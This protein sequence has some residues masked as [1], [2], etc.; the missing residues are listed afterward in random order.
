MKTSLTRASGPTSLL[1]QLIDSPALVGA[2]RQLPPAAFS[3]LVQHVGVEDAGEL[4]ALATTEQLVGAFDEDLFRAAR[5]GQRE[6]F[7]PGRFLT[8]LEVLL[9][10]GE[11]TA[12]GRVA[13]LSEDFVTNA[14]NS[15]VIVLDSDAL[16]ERMTEGGAEADR[17][18]KRLSCALSEQIDG[19][20][21]VA[22][23]PDGW[24]AIFSLILALDRDHRALLER[25][26]DRCASISSEL[27]DDLAALST[28][29][30]EGASLME[31]V[32]AEREDRRAKA[33]FVEP[34]AARAFLTLARTPSS[35][36]GPIRD[37]IARG[38]FREIE[39]PGA[40]PARAGSSTD[41]RGE[42]HDEP[43]ARRELGATQ[44]RGGDP[45]AANR[46]AGAPTE[47]ARLLQLID[48]IA[49]EEPVSRRQRALPATRSTIVE[50]LQALRARDGRRFDE[51]MAELGFLANVLTAGA[52]T[53]DR[54]FRA[55]EATEAA[56]ATVALGAEL[57][58]RDRH[59]LKGAATVAHLLEVLA[60]E[61]ADLLFRVAS[62]R[63]ALHDPASAG[64]VRERG[65]L[66]GTLKGF[67]R[68]EPARSRRAPSSS[69]P[70]R[71]G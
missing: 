14:I 22:R 51:R 7:D 1:R 27:V 62:A 66:A 3:K 36:G 21:L 60:D 41:E 16:Q 43:A 10:A 44:G 63:L 2:V 52:T 32:E 4:V 59:A 18:D 30:S 38:Y 71:R 39:P 19:Y 9:E 69:R 49:E 13:E 58:A 28:V 35:S 64:F 55:S 8:W 29:L 45:L 31:D 26:L 11:A 37:P 46:R 47:A 61:P 20:L 57:V 67:G 23:N 42:H 70:R 12:A 40:G 6:A 24:D 17:A 53:D 25:V 65:E 34:R 68:S 33:G 56:L 15:L 5:P 54:P 50:A 48:Q